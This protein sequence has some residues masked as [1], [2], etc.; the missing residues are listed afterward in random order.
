MSAGVL[1]CVGDVTVANDG[2]A[3]CSG[4][5]N[6]I[7]VPE[8]FDITLVDPEIY[9]QFFIAGFALVGT[10]WGAALGVRL[11]LKMIR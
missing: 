7:P 8:P 6:L 4:V 10:I 5:W 9:A 1:Q 2:A 11:L 3:L